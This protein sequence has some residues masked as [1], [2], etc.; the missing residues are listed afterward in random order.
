LI[1][2]ISLAAAALTVARVK[3]GAGG[4]RLEVERAQGEI[5]LL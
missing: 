4:L 3:A 1:H 5:A 2:A